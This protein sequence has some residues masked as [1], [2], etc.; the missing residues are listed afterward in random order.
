MSEDEKEVSSDL[1][2]GSNSNRLG[3]T[4]IRRAA[5]Q[6]SE[7]AGKRGFSGPDLVLTVRSNPTN[8][9]ENKVVE[10]L[11]D[12]YLRSSGIGSEYSAEPTLSGCIPGTNRTK[13]Y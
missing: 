3:Q 2:V 8:M 7:P 12:P 4:R 9:R 1:N 13:Q 5:V 10:N 6:G 11:Q